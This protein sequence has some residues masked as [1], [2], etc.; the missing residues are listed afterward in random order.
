MDGVKL[1]SDIDLGGQPWTP[2]GYGSWF[3][4]NFDG[5][6]YHIRN[7]YINK[8][9]LTGNTHF[10]AL[11]GGTNNINSSIRKSVSLRQN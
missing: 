6:G 9:D 8:S 4:G 7:M 1:A 5:Q 11:I 3:N 2:I 10:C